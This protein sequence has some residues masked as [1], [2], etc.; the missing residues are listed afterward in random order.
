M[1]H[2]S[3]Y[4]DPILYTCQKPA[5]HNFHICLMSAGKMTYK[6]ILVSNARLLIYTC[7]ICRHIKSP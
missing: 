3:R 6:F 7:A 5:L 2:V 4:C 1:P